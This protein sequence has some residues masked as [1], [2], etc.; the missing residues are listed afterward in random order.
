MAGL[1]W[2]WCNETGEPDGQDRRA[3]PMDSRDWQSGGWD[4]RKTQQQQKR[5]PGHAEKD[6]KTVF[7]ITLENI[8]MPLL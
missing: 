5:Y 8:M 7:M 6:Y 1:V 4:G 2:D 3:G